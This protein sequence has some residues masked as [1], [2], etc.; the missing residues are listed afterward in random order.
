MSKKIVFISI[1]AVCFLGFKGKDS[2]K[3]LGLKF[4]APT[5]FGKT[6]VTNP[7]PGEI[8][9]DS[10]DNK[11]WGY[12]TSNNWVEL[13]SGSAIVPVG[14]VL[15]FGG[16]TPPNGYRFANGDLLNIADYPD[17]F[18]AIGTAFGG[19]GVST[20]RLPDLRGRFL[21]G[22]DGGTGRDPDAGSRSAMNTGGNAGNA[23][24]SIQA[25][26]LRSHTHSF[27]VGLSGG[28]TVPANGAGSYVS[29]TTSA[30]GGSETRPVNA[31]VNFIVKVN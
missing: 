9:Y 8:V 23:V 24:G 13:S 19:D 5:V 3:T 27:T 6:N 21:R 22:V 28:G 16:T 15:P 11:F 7:E 18:A 4:S 17:L 20:F 1:L 30:A 12:D 2:F 26:Q 14:V 29:N 25:D 31:Y 10:S